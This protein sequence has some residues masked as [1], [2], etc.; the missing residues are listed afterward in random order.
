MAKNI[1]TLVENTI[2]SGRLYPRPFDKCDACD[3]KII[4]CWGK[5]MSP[6]WRHS[7]KGDHDHKPNSESFNHLFAKKILTDYLTDGKKINIYHHCN[8]YRIT[9]PNSANKFKQ[10]VIF[11]DC[12]FDIGCLDVSDNLVFGIEICETH[13]VENTNTRNKIPWIETKASDVIN[14][15]DNSDKNI[16]NIKLCDYST[17]ECCLS[18]PKFLSGFQMAYI[19]GYMCDNIYEC[20]ALIIHSIAITGKYTINRS[21]CLD[22]RFKN[23]KICDSYDFSKIKNKNNVWNELVSRQKCIRCN[24]KHDVSYGRPYCKKCYIEIKECNE[25][26]DSD[27]SNYDTITDEFYIYVDKELQNKHRKELNWLDEIKG[28]W[29]LG[30]EC[31]FCNKNYIDHIDH[32]NNEKYYNNNS[33]FVSC[34]TWWFGEKKCICIICLDKQCD[35]KNIKLNNEHIIHKI[36]EEI[37]Y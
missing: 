36:N 29:I 1:N 7:T 27:N 4:L 33:N 24:K 21:W 12:C 18:S 32:I 20:D 15:L 14:S 19:L 37:I 31:V 8:N 23:E 26:C 17:K 9:I 10:E 34:Y 6:Y 2:K 11:E 16:Q 13:S 30:N 22:K 3:K 25:D 5:T 28:G 35:M